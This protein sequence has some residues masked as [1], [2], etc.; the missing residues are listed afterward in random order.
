MG[1]EAGRPGGATPRGRS[2]LRGR[3]PASRAE[4]CVGRAVQCEQTLPLSPRAQSR[5]TWAG[6]S[7]CLEPH[8]VERVGPAGWTQPRHEGYTTTSSG[9]WSSPRS[10]ER[11]AAELPRGRLRGVGTGLRAARGAGR[12]RTSSRLRL[13]WSAWAW[14][15]GEAAPGICGETRGGSRVASSQ[16]AVPSQLVGGCSSFCPRHPVLTPEPLRPGLGPGPAVPAG[17]PH[18]P[19]ES[20]IPSGHCGAGPAPH[21][22]GAARCDMGPRPLSCH[23]GPRGMESHTRG[24]WCLRGAPGPL[25]KADPPLFRG[26]GPGWF[27]CFNQSDGEFRNEVWEHLG[28]QEQPLPW[29]EPSGQALSC[30]GPGH[31]PWTGHL[32]RAGRSDLRALAGAPATR[33]DPTPVPGQLLSPSTSLLLPASPPGQLPARPGPPAACLPGHP[34]P[35]A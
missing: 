10:R 35:L 5:V 16:L 29:E 19:P 34:E 30:P 8:V 24:S 9:R 28:G 15:R 33:A 17:H 20:C 23:G 27:S 21:C 11:P 4:P 7:V 14:A 6:P 3:S 13:C 12:G 1:V 26:A 31:G 32:L 18:T 22:P 2:W 25:P